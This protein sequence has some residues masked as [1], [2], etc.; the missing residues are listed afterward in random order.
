[1]KQALHPIRRVLI[2]IDYKLYDANPG[3]KI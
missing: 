2:G 3:E 1:M